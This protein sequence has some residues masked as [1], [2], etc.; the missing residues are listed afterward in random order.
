[1]DT[2]KIPWKKERGKVYS[3]L[4]AKNKAKNFQIDLMKLEPNTSYSEH[5]HPDVE[6]VYIVKGSF[7]DHRGTFKQGDFVINE[8]GSKHATRTGSAGCELL[9]FWCGKVIPTKK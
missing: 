8:K 9:C 1:M 5:L 3:K 2:S 7:M 4:L 6:W